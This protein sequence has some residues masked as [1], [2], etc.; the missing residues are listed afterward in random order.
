MLSGATFLQANI[1]KPETKVPS[2]PTYRAAE[3]Q[4]TP[5]ASRE[6]TMMPATIAP[7]W[8][9]ALISDAPVARQSAV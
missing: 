9:I 5:A 8:L 6:V 7:G 1:T 2:A 4:A 3:D